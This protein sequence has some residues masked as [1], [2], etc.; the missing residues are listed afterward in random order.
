[1]SSSL[2]ANAIQSFVPNDL[3]MPETYDDAQL[4]LTDYLRNVVDALNDKEIGQYNTV[5]LVTGQHWFTPGNANVLRYVYRKVI[6]LGGLN[7]FTV[8]NPQNTAHGIAITANTIVTRIYGTA[9]DPSTSF[10]PLP[11]VDMTGGGNHIQLSM[12]G[13]NVILR[14]NFNYSGYTTAYVVVEYIQN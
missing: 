13:T 5:E 1:M 3:I 4:I 10:I 7:D 9:T 14:S 12:D 6:D 8:T 2:P 11:Y